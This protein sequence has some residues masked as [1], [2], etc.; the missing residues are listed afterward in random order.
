MMLSRVL[1]FPFKFCLFRA[2]PLFI[3]YF[4][5]IVITS[6][7]VSVQVGQMDGARTSP[8]QFDLALQGADTMATVENVDAIRKSN[9]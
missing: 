7:C 5:N 1:L 3:E 4:D 8:S 2:S 6:V 9:H